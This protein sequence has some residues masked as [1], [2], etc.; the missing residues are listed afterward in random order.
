[1]RKIVDNANGVVVIEDAEKEGLDTVVAAAGGVEAVVVG[2]DASERC[3]V[4][5]DID[6]EAED[7]VGAVLE[8]R[9]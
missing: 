2:I 1:M 5:V 7:Y 6:E 8:K 3:I 4:N 9:S